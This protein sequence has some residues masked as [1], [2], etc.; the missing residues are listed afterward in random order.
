MGTAAAKMSR[1]TLIY[2]FPYETEL[3]ISLSI[4]LLWNSDDNKEFLAHVFL[5]EIFQRRLNFFSSASIDRIFD[6]TKKPRLL[7]LLKAS[8]VLS[9]FHPFFFACLHFII[10]MQTSA[11]YTP[12]FLETSRFSKEQKRELSESLRN[13]TW[14]AYTKARFCI[15][16]EKKSR[17]TVYENP[18]KNV[19]FWINARI[20]QF[21]GKY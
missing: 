2:W 1:H 3:K 10:T 6:K 11:L 12:F 15:N 16:S 18:W 13:C 19:S 14:T 21:Q 5:T 8:V 20:M 9:L 4:T 17:H 7:S